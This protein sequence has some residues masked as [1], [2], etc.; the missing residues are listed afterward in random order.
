M[1]RLITI[2]ALILAILSL[3]LNLFLIQ[4]LNQARTAAIAT[5]DRTSQRLGSLA[6]VSF[7]Q[8]VRINQ[9]FPVSGELPLHQDFTFPISMT[10]PVNTSVN[11]DVN[12]PLGPVSMPVAVNASVPIKLDVPVTISRTIP[13]SLTVPLD[14][15]VPVEVRLRD[16]GIEPTIKETQDEIQRL[17]DALQ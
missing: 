11:V 7:K 5:L 10:V 8:T 3:A 14:V 16:L 2:V 4:R 13:Y 1:S 15:Q 9:S 12:T 6:D 17:R